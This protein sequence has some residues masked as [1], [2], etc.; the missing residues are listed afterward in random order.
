MPQDPTQVNKPDIDQPSQ[1]ATG[2]LV[3]HNEK[4]I[5]IFDNEDD[6]NDAMHGYELN[7]DVEIDDVLDVINVI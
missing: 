7:N 2:Y 3:R 5:G 6:A 4:I 1:Q